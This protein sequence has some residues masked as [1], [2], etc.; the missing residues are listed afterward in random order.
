MKMYINEVIFQSI[1]ILKKARISLEN[2]MYWTMG[3]IIMLRKAFV[4]KKGERC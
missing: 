4:M 2:F 1:L 3:L